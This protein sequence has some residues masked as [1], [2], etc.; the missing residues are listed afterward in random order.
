MEP[1]TRYAR[2]SGGQLAYQV[3]GEGPID[4]VYLTAAASNVDS[5][6]EIPQFARFNERLASFSRLIMFDRLGN[7]AS[8]RTVVDG[9]QSLEDWAQDLRLVLDTVGS[10]R[11]A[12]VAVADAGFMAMVFAARYP[13][14][15]SRLVLA[16][17][18]ARWLAAPDYP[19]GVEPEFV[20]RF[21][22]AVEEGWGTEDFALLICPG[23]AVDPQVRRLYARQLRA[24][25]TPGMS[26]A[27]L[28][29]LVDVD[30]RDVLPAIRAPTLVLH[31]REFS[32]API[33]QGR[34]LAEHIPDARLLELDGADSALPL[35]DSETVVV[36]LEEFLTGGRHSPNPDRMLA[37]VVFT[38]LV[39][40][41]A[42]ATEL[43]NRAWAD[44]MDRHD[45]LVRG[46]VERW[47]GRVWKSTGDGI[48]ATFPMPRDGIRCAVAIRQ[49]LAGLGLEM[50]AGIHA[51]EVEVLDHDLGGIA[52]HVAARVATVAQP[53]QVLLSRTVA[54]LI[55]GSGI[56]LAEQ[57]TR[58]LRGVDG[59]WKLYSV[60]Q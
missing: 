28:R 14:R 51:G 8:D 6:W 47:H 9:V 16:N 27:Q 37:T 3:L 39:A 10:E 33:G 42:R 54:D 38:D 49:G 11:A 21:L 46:E 15:V 1:E 12:V 30:L 56:L 57:G 58:T 40:S 55:A 24:S 25:A 19:P 41:T 20:Q 35:G 13:E 36:A 60:E 2:G 53:R 31:R 18:C 7:G 50:R 48:L 22:A 32:L 26:A 59:R 5:R 52:V 34:Y 44:L 17:A 43:G 29:A 45:R 4:L 23:L